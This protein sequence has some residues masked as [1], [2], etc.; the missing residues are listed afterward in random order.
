ME[1]EHGISGAEPQ[2]L[3]QTSGPSFL[4]LSGVGAEKAPEA[5][6]FL[7]TQGPKRK[8]PITYETAGEA[9]GSLLF[10]WCE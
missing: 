10:S 6:M 7:N 9:V 4:V 8:E 2:T 1:P 3:N 5:K